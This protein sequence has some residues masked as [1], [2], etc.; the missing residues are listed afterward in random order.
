M[1]SI[2]VCG[3]TAFTSGVIAFSCG[4]L[5]AV[6][7][8][9]IIIRKHKAVKKCKEN[10]VSKHPAAVS[11][12]YLQQSDQSLEIP[13]QEHSQG[14]NVELQQNE[15]SKHPVAVSPLYLQQSDQSPQYEEIKGHVVELQQNI[16]YILTKANPCRLKQL[17]NPVII[18]IT[19]MV[20]SDLV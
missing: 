1:D 19:V 15:V 8:N 3:I 9:Y 5:I 2:T 16:A 6:F 14:H 10:E 12:F 11:P 13:M 4:V 20:M 17:T 18:C 7:C